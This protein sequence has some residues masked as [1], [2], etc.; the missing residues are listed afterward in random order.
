MPDDD[1]TRADDLVAEEG[2]NQQGTDAESAGRSPGTGP[3][4]H[5]DADAGGGGG[6][7]AGTPGAAATGSEG[8]LDA[9]PEPNEPG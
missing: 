7:G 9:A 3:G 8:L 5:P 4:E 6:S 1:P 2:V